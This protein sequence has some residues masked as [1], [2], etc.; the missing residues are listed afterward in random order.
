MLRLT[1]IALASTSVAATSLLAL[2]GGGKQLKTDD[3]KALYALGC[4]VGQIGDL[5][6]PT[7]SEIDTILMGVKDTVTRQEFQVNLQEA[8]PKTHRCSR[9]SRR[10]ILRRWQQ[11]ASGPGESW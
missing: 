2:R 1:I 6:S 7:P 8:L 3:D 10:R 9:P 11:L 5:D 4:N